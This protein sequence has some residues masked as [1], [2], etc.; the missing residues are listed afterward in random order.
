MPARPPPASPDVTDE[1]DVAR[2]FLLYA[3]GL[4]TA[5]EIAKVTLTG[6]AVGRNRVFFE[7]RTSNL[8]RA[9]TLNR[10]SGCVRTPGRDAG[11]AA[12][13]ALVEDVRVRCVWN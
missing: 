9:V 7:P 5:A 3:A 13:V 10:K 2:R 12:G 4:M 6:K 1:D 8:V 11:F